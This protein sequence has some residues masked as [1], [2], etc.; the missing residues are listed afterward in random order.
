MHHKIDALLGMLSTKMFIL[1][2][3]HFILL[4]N[5]IYFNT[6]GILNKPLFVYLLN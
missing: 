6:R 5:V 1:I 2:K 4:Y 3:N